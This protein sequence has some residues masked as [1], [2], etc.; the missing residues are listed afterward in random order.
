MIQFFRALVLLFPLVVSGQEGGDICGAPEV[1]QLGGLSC[2]ATFFRADGKTVLAALIT[3]SE[4][5]T[6]EMDLV[7]EKY[8][9]SLF[10]PAEG[11]VA[12]G[13]LRA[14]LKHHATFHVLDQLG[15]EITRAGGFAQTDLS[16]FFD[17]LIEREMGIYCLVHYM[18]PPFEGELI[19][20]ED[21]L[22]GK[23]G[24]GPNVIASK[25]AGRIICEQVAI[26]T[27][28]RCENLGVEIKFNAIQRGA[29]GQLEYKIVARSRLANHPD[30]AERDASGR[31]FSVPVEYEE[32]TYGLSLNGTEK[33]MT[34]QT[35]MLCGQ[36]CKRLDR[37]TSSQ[38]R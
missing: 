5:M 16:I 20:C 12:L 10:I 11:V 17:V 32:R 38:K 37:P 2:K 22:T 26:E 3:T 35:W 31:V 29:G 13:D 15:Y 1:R 6:Q 21:G 14:I 28:S 25:S 19:A 9:Y 7:S 34:D 8:L 18:K 24:Y 36:S 27:S 33:R 23:V 30:L 4:G